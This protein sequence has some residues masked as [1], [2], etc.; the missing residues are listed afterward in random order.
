MP[1]QFFYLNEPGEGGETGFPRANKGAQPRDFLD[2]SQG[3]SVKPHRL[4]VLIFY[5]MLPNGEFDQTSLHTGCDVKA[6]TKWAANF[7]FWNMPQTSS[8]TARRLVEDLQNR[9]MLRFERGMQ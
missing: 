7:W 6:G 1:P 8:R 4:A 2:C 9:S 5:S 3:M